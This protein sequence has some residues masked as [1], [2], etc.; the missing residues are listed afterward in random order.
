[1][2]MRGIFTPDDVRRMHRNGF[3]VASL[4]ESHFLRQ[5]AATIVSG[6]AQIEA[7]D[8]ERAQTL[9]TARNN[10]DRHGRLLQGFFQKPG[11]GMTQCNFVD[12]TDG[13]MNDYVQVLHAQG[14]DFER[15]FKA[16][17][18]LNQWTHE[19]IIELAGAIDK[20]TNQ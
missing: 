1:M 2:S 18:D 14:L 7:I 10:K 12:L 19:H 15:F 11:D 13:R 20:L 9:N 3:L 6:L 17:H 16:F 5:R 8:T 4:R